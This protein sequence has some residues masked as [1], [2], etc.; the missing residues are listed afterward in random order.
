MNKN[1]KSVGNVLSANAT[2]FAYLSV[3]LKLDYVITNRE[4]SLH[5]GSGHEVIFRL[6]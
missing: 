1:V 2:R 5:L 4:I 6:V 3:A